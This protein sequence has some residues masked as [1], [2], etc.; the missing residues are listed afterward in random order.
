VTDE[1]YT[2]VA[3]LHRPSPDG[4]PDGSVFD[5]PR[6]AEHVA[7][8]HRMR[9]AGYLV[10]A[11]PFADAPGHGLTILRLPGADQLDLATQFATEDDQSVVTGLFDVTIRP[12]NVLMHAELQSSLASDSE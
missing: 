6:F 9:E 7:F 4:A 11:G 3:L 2:W 5:D 1:A 10:A 12:W 8:L